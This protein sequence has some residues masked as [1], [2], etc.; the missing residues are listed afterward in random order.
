MTCPGAGELKQVCE[1]QAVQIDVYPVKACERQNINLSSTGRTLRVPKQVIQMVVFLRSSGTC[2]TVRPTARLIVLLLTASAMVACSGSHGE[3][4]STDPANSSNS[5]IKADQNTEAG[6]SKYSPQQSYFNGGNAKDD[7]M[8]NPSSELQSQSLFTASSSRNHLVDHYISNTPPKFISLTSWKFDFIA[9]ELALDALD[10]PEAKRMF[11]MS[12]AEAAREQGAIGKTHAALSKSRLGLVA[13][14]AG[15]AEAAEAFFKDSTAV[16]KKEPDENELALKIAYYELALLSWQRKQYESA[17]KYLRERLALHES[18]HGTFTQSNAAFMNDLANCLYY[19]RK[20]DEADRLYARVLSVAQRFKE[21]TDYTLMA[22]Y[23]LANCRFEEKQFADALALY[24]MT[25]DKRQHVTLRMKECEEAIAKLPAD[26]RVARGL[27]A[28]IG[29]A[30]IWKQLID[31]GIKSSTHGNNWE[32]QKVFK[33]A[34][35]EAKA[36]GADNS[37]ISE[38]NIYLA[39]LAFQQGNFSEAEALYR[40][41]INS[42]EAV[43]KK[44]GQKAQANSSANKAF[45]HGLARL[46]IC[47]L[48]QKDY[49]QATETL[50]KLNAVA[51]SD[52]W[53]T[54]IPV[55][56]SVFENRRLYSN[57]E[58]P[59]VAIL[60]SVCQNCVKAAGEKNTM[61]RA[62]AIANLA[63]AYQIDRKTDLSAPLFKQALTVASAAAD[64]NELQIYRIRMDAAMMYMSAEQFKLSEQCYLPALAYAESNPGKA[65]QRLRQS[66]EYLYALYSNW[67]QPDKQEEF[68][69][70][71]IAL[72][73]VN[74]ADA[75]PESKISE[76]RNNLT[77]FANIEKAKGNFSKSAE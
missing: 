9:G 62:V 43:V 36:M 42:L 69:K 50:K 45:G 30:S 31:S 10:L 38:T 40:E 26:Q 8:N 66:V 24:K 3:S 75:S 52:T 56:D 65:D 67:K 33:A 51:S 6:L 2:G 21:D 20:F 41:S 18:L 16:L 74:S 55:L 19:E 34:L 23:N 58:G 25:N 48:A 63:R 72:N 71:K 64:K 77:E 46:L 4:M 61:L 44:S 27:P 35:N 73:S 70:R 13:R 68:L 54:L 37:K 29:D 11:E 53:L 17:E 59:L 32:T 60:S 15:Q 28:P 1:E 7:W 49:P 5:P 57:G 12:L 22:S 47:Q 76:Q 14:K 39:D